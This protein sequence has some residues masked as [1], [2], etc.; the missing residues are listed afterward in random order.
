MARLLRKLFGIY[1][2]LVIWKY[3]HVQVR[4]KFITPTTVLKFWV[5]T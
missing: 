2:A 1:I 4:T 3:K 5:G